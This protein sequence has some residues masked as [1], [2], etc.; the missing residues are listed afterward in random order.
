MSTFYVSQTKNK[1][2]DFQFCK[3]D[4]SDSEYIENNNILT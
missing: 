2:H 4:E 3:I 1:K